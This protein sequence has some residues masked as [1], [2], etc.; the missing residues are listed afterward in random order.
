MLPT[1]PSDRP[2][3]SLPG[4]PPPGPP[5]G[6]PQAQ[7]LAD[8]P[9]TD[10]VPPAATAHGTTII[11]P[12]TT[13]IRPGAVAWGG[14]PDA[15]DGGYSSCE[16]VERALAAVVGNPAE[17][18]GLL[19]ELAPSRLWVPLP[20]RPF[21]DGAAVRLPLI[22]YQG[23]VFVPC[24]TSVQ[25]LNA[26]A[27][28]AET[29]GL[30]PVTGAELAGTGP[31]GSGPA[32]TGTTG[33]GPAGTGPA[34]PDLA[35]GAVGGRYW[36]RAGDARPVPHVVLPAIGLARRLPSGVGLAINP[37]STPGL[38]L[39]PECVPYLARLTAPAILAQA[40]AP[41]PGGLDMEHLASGNG[42]RFLVG[43]PPAE[44][45]ALLAETR[46]ALRALPFARQAS[47]AWLSVPGQGEG[48]LVSVL[49]DDPA[50]E[51]ARTAVVDA[52]E[53]AAAAAA[54]RVPFPVDVIF[55]GEPGSEHPDDTA[56]P[57]GATG[58]PGE[59]CH[60]ALP[61]ER[62][63]APPTRIA[64]APS[65]RRSSAVAP[66]DAIDAWIAENTRPFYHRD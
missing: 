23:T 35:G 16:A 44:P 9:L 55:P 53:H 15:R 38:P 41:P 58:L 3:S 36:Q 62:R 27:V 45:T 18:P 28:R 47:R 26:W 42:T 56:F 29:A 59:R 32:G 12:G 4:G 5:E 39:F 37:D 31:T 61:A 65:T 2:G 13:I 63:S 1:D 51:R 7:P 6:T 60:G 46:A 14:P 11:R 20:H 64:A 54:L 22:G 33:T 17:L 50:S 25:R 19:A 57:G 48:L 43:H 40:G 52:I 24:F 34:G 10:I 8:Q 66:A 30:D 49:L 21:T